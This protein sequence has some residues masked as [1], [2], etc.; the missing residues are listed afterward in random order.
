M[1]RLAF[2]QRLDPVF[3]NFEHRRGVE[4]IAL[5]RVGEGAQD[6]EFRRW[7]T[8]RRNQH[9]CPMHADMRERGLEKF[10]QRLLKISFATRF[11]SPRNRNVD[12]FVHGQKRKLKVVET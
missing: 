12:R 2:R 10:L 1:H 5:L 3:P 7:R 9:T 8:G 6:A 4:G 11:Y